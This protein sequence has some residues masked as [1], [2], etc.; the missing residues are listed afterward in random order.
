MTS[1]LQDTYHRLIKIAEENPQIV[2]ATIPQEDACHKVKQGE[3]PICLSTEDILDLQG[4]EDPNISLENGNGP[5]PLDPMEI[6]ELYRQL[7]LRDAADGKLDT[8]LRAENLPLPH[9]DRN[10]STALRF[11]GKQWTPDIRL[12]AYLRW[13]QDKLD[14]LLAKPSENLQNSRNYV[15]GR[16]AAYLEEGYPLMGEEQNFITKTATHL[17]QK[18]HHFAANLVF[19][20]IGRARAIP[21]RESYPFEDLARTMY[22]S[23]KDKWGD[24]S[25]FYT[26]LFDAEGKRLPFSMRIGKKSNRRLTARKR[27]FNRLDNYMA[28]KTVHP[29]EYLH[30]A[31]VL[32]DTYIYRYYYFKKTGKKTVTGEEYFR[33]VVVHEALHDAAIQQADETWGNVPIFSWN[34]LALTITQQAPLS[35]DRMEECIQHLGNLLQLQRSALDVRLDFERNREAGPQT[36][37]TVEKYRLAKKLEHLASEAMEYLS[38][39]V[40]WK[41]VLENKDKPENSIVPRK[42]PDTRS[43][44][45]NPN[46]ENVLTKFLS[47]EK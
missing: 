46:E 45:F 19:K 5:D 41:L 2:I 12:A 31:D 23:Q 30:V 24:V 17:T 37:E 18:E 29:G 13:Y 15:A 7:I 21:Y 40:A 14:D 11:Y 25:V 42:T 20:M 9:L 47:R 8:F 4:S 44:L 32:R 16:I 3:P 34:Q 1:K 43:R 22:F 35:H 6:L 38:D 36:P 39:E 33:T 10:H 27:G 28:G 26:S